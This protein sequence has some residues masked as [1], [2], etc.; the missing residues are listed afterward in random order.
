VLS[1]AAVEI[2]MDRPWKGNVRELEN[3]VERAVL[4]ASGGTIEP[5]H[6]RLEEGCLPVI[7]L[8][9]ST[10]QAGGSGGGSLWEM[11]R[12][13]IFKTLANVKG[14]RTHA[15]KV[16]GISI[17]TLRNKLREYRQQAGPAAADQAQPEE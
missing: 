16:L 5:D 15:A 2:L 6:F 7:P 1:E 17:R 12:E 4:M 8:T 3:A 10:G 13:L 14:N 9:Q 11:E